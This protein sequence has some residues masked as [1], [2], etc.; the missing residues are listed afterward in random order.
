[1]MKCIYNA[2]RRKDIEKYVYILSWR[3]SNAPTNDKKRT[4]LLGLMIILN[5]SKISYWCNC[6]W[7]LKT[8]YIKRISSKTK[9]AW[10]I[11]YT[12]VS[13][14][15]NWMQI[16]EQR[17]ADGR[18]TIKSNKVKHAINTD[19]DPSQIQMAFFRYIFFKFIF[20]LDFWCFFIFLYFSL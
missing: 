6:S 11:G 16:N 17:E 2:N 4:N 18:H 13:H 14:V 8:R 7:S 5:V 19:P 10:Y 1:M 9:T 3:M 20:F 15:H 12:D